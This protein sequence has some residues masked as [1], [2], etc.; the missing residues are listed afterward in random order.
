MWKW[1]AVSGTVS[2]VSIG[3]SNSQVV[4]FVL[5]KEGAYRSIVMHFDKDWNDRLSVLSRDQKISAHCQI[6][7]ANDAYIYVQHCEINEK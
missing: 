1:I 6:L 3:N 7:K 4:T 2:N 5:T